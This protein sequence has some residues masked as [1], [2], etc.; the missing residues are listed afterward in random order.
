MSAGWRAL[1]LCAAFPGLPWIEDSQERS[2]AGVC[3][4]TAVCGACPVR[5]DCAD[6]TDRHRV[7]SG[8][9]AGR[10]RAPDPSSRGEAA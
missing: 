5:S 10:D 6:Y 1:A 4:M 8:F 9:W 2:A 7:T 3:A